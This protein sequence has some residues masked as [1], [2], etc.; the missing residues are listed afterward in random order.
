PGSGET[1]GKGWKNYC[2]GMNQQCFNLPGFRRVPARLN[3]IFEHNIIQGFVFLR[4]LEPLWLV[5][6]IKN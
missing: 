1:F 2:V 4:A 5:K 3:S 6:A